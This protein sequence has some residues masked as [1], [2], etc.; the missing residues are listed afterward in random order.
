[1]HPKYQKRFGHSVLKEA[2][3]RVYQLTEFGE[4]SDING[5][6]ERRTRVKNEGSEER[7]SLDNVEVF[8][9]K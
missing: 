5:G 1:M 3:G 2:Q 4:E 9:F 7:I 6:E 8:K